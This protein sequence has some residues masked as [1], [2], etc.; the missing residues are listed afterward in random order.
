MNNIKLFR[1]MKKNIEKICINKEVMVIKPIVIGIAGD[2]ATGKSTLSNLIKNNIFSSDSIIIEGD[3]YHKWERNDYH[4]EKYTHLNPKANFLDKQAKDLED[5]K[6]FRPIQKVN[7]NHQLGKFTEFEIVNPS[8]HIIINGLHTLY[9]KQL[10]DNI[11]FKIYMDAEYNLKTFWKINRDCIERKKS[12]DNTLKVIEKR[13]E[14]YLKYIYPQMKFADMS[15]IYS[16]NNLKLNSKLISLE[17]IPKVNLKIIL[18]KDIDPNE[19]LKVFQKCGINIIRV[20]NMKKLVLFLNYQEI[21]KI[22]FVIHKMLDFLKE[23]NTCVLDN[24]ESYSDC[25]LIVQMIFIFL[26]KKKNKLEKTNVKS[27]YI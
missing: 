21:I 15:I 16:D 14:D 27:C 10:R 19:M 9:L 2:S 22:K 25:E 11:D 1:V 13:H 7:Y 26:F 5:L 8:K 3:S 24:Y 6:N 17:Y 18:S 23:F 12:L 4:W 20:K